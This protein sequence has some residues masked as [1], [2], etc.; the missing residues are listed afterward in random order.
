MVRIAKA[1]VPAEAPIHNNLVRA[2]LNNPELHRGFVSLA[3]RVHS[4]SHLDARM[5]ELVVLRTVARLRATYEWGNHVVGAR[6]AGVTDDEI[7]RLRDG[8]LDAFADAERSALRFAEAVEDRTVDNA[9]WANAAVHFS[10]VELLDMT[11][12]VGFYGMASRF[13]LAVDVDLDEGLPG[14]DYP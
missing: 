10:D 8:D 11:M 14:L 5:R 13:V 4:A 9:V 2:T 6:L 12:L 7:R 3:G 1:D